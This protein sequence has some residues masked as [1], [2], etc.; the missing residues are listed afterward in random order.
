[1]HIL[2]KRIRLCLQL[3]L[4][5]TKWALLLTR[6]EMVP[7]KSRPGGKWSRCPQEAL[8]DQVKAKSTRAAQDEAGGTNPTCPLPL[9]QGTI[10]ACRWPLCVFFWLISIAPNI[11]LVSSIKKYRVQGTPVDNIEPVVLSSSHHSNH[12]EYSTFLPCESL[13]LRSNCGWISSS[14]DSHLSII[15]VYW[16]S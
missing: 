4:A 14:M 12:F 8:R 16:C 7:E 2:L 10:P 1:M 11:S 3:S 15:F 5:L 6:R 9:C 13:Y